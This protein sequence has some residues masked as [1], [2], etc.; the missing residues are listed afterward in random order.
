V[1]MRRADD[2]QVI[3]AWARTDTDVTLQLSGGNGAI[4]DM[5]GGEEPFGTF[6]GSAKVNLPGATCNGDDPVVPCP[7]GGPVALLEVIE[8]ELIIQEMQADGTM[9]AL[10][11]KTESQNDNE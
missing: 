11:A 5:S 7:V 10:V 8:G 1:V 3:A 9:S 2:T 6:V 4:Y